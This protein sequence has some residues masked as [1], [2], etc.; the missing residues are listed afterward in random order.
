MSKTPQNIR[1]VTKPD[2][3]ACDKF[4]LWCSSLLFLFCYRFT[5]LDLVVLAGR[6]MCERPSRP[7][8]SQYFHLNFTFWKNQRFS[9]YFLI[10]I[11]KWN[12]PLLPSGQYP[13]V[14]NEPSINSLLNKC[15]SPFHQHTM[16]NSLIKYWKCSTILK[17]KWKL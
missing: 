4:P 2:L 10:K 15:L 7:V 14:W 12:V 11:Q 8:G 13:L 5:C 16:L 3:F 17:W 9:F 1:F 6:I